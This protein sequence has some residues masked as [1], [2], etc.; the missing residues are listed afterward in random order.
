MKKSILST[1]VLL[2][3]LT[4]ASVANAKCGH[5]TI[6]SMNFTSAEVLANVDKII[7]NAGYECDAELVLG[8]TVPTMTSMVEKGQPDIAPE[9]PPALLPQLIDR[10]LSEGKLLQTVEDISDGETNGWFI[11][12]YFADKHPE[13]KTIRDVM[14]HPELFPS[15]DDPKKGAIYNG[16]QGWGWTVITAQLFKAFDG[17]KA[18]FELVNTGSAAG[19]DSSIVKAFATQKA[20]VGYYWSPTALLGKYQMVRIDPGVPYND[21]EWKRCITKADCP[22]PKPT[23]WPATDHV[24]SYVTKSFSTR[25]SPDVMQYMKTRAWSSATLNKLMAWMAD[26]QA[27]GEDGA[28]HFLKENKN[29]WSKWVSK[30]AAERISASL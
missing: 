20:W 26:N 29:L 8:D 21:V 12:K 19:L 9:V 13:I 22:D 27:T 14:K 16:P 24:Y 10:G 15:P 11:P 5:V 2:G 1:C 25:V 17:T 4:G 7:L 3:F 30:E 23:G 6:A 18:G 28:K